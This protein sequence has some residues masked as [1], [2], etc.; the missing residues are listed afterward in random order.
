MTTK[1][2]VLLT[3][4]FLSPWA[5]AE[6][7][8]GLFIEPGIT[9][10]SYSSSIAYPAPFS[11]STGS[12]AGLGLMARLGFH[13][14]D[15]FFV[16]ADARYAQ[17]T[18]KDSTNNLSAS[19][20]EYDLG[21]VAGIQMPFAGLRVWATYIVTSQ[22]S[23]GASNGFQ[24]K[25]SDGSGYRIGAGFHLLAVSLNLEYQQIKYSNTTI[26]ELGPFTPNT[27]TSSINFNGGGWIVSVSF[28]FEM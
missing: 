8:T 6:G 19:A 14:S 9:Y 5:A 20:Q 23:P 27:N 10:Q 18:F 4:F 1:L 24:Y 21:P 7:A 12:V 25:F 3:A 16:A 2:L 22:L 17:P 15:V 11:N 13:V 26:E 28:P